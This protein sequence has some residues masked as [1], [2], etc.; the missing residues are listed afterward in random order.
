MFMDAEV[1]KTLMLKGKK[2]FRRMGIKKKKQIKV[3]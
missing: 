2:K 3:M 1:C